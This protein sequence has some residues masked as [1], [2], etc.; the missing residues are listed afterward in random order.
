[1]GTI[2]ILHNNAGIAINGDS[3]DI[4]IEGWN[5]VNGINLTGR[6]L[7]GR[8]IGNMVFA[9][10]IPFIAL[11]LALFFK[12]FVSLSLTIVEILFVII[13]FQE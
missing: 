12:I 9:I 5:R 2:D 13:Q 10:A 7:V 4:K 1:M 11:L 8:T 6:M 3:P